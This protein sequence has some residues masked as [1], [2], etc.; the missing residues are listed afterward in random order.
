MPTYVFKPIE[1]R[2]D[3][4]APNRPLSPAAD[5]MSAAS[6]DMMTEQEKDAQAGGPVTKDN[7]PG[8][9]PAASTAEVLPAETIEEQGIG[10]RTPYPTG[11][12]APPEE[13]V[14]RFQ[15]IKTAKP[16]HNEPNKPLA[17]ERR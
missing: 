8:V 14:T 15:G 16:P 4:N 3:R 9:G 1:P 12:P 17:R 5:S 7:V 11:D 2:Q 10:P 6:I 13:S